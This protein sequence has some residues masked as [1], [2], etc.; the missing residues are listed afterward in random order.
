M[1]RVK[2][3]C[4]CSVAGERGDGGETGA[5]VSTHRVQYSDAGL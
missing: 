4:V 5:A 2:R 1:R 3:V